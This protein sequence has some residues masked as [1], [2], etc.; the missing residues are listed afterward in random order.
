MP[1]TKLETIHSLKQ[2]IT[3]SR[4]RLQNLWDARGYTDSI[5]LAASVELDDLLN[6]YQKLSDEDKS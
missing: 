4:Q 1:K 5:V 2:K 3:A 6:E